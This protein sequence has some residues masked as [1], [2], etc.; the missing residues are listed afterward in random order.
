MAF[1][2]ISVNLSSHIQ[3]SMV[4]FSSVEGTFVSVSPSICRRGA[5]MLQE[6]LRSHKVLITLGDY[7]AVSPT[8]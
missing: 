5:A 7:P 6:V 1:T 8:F 3:I 4:Q 2:H